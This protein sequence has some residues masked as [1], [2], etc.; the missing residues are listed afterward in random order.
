MK[1][2]KKYLKKRLRN[3]IDNILYFENKNIERCIQR[4][5][6]EESSRFVIEEMKKVSGLAFP[7][8]YSLLEFALNQ[9]END[10]IFLEFGV[11]K[12]DTINY[13]ASHISNMIYGFDSFEGLPEDWREG[14]GKG[15]FEVDNLPLVKENVRLIPG[16]FDKTLQ[17]FIDQHE[18]F[19]SFIHIDCDLYSSTKIVLSV[20]SERIRNGTIIVFDEFFNYPGWKDGEYKAFM[21]YINDTHSEFEYIGYNKY[22]EQVAVKILSIGNKNRKL[23]P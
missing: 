7:D 18:G 9:A 12:G 16:W 4:I 23:R 1:S 19:C 13:I 22:H 3:Y 17:P 14:Y 5:A 21:E 8:R 10:G 20:L 15:T 11:Y 6:L 2:I